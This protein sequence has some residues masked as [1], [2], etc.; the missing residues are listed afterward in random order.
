MRQNRGLE[1]AAET[2]ADV[3]SVAPLHPTGLRSRCSLEFPGGCAGSDHE[4]PAQQAAGHKEL[5]GQVE[6][7]DREEGQEADMKPRDFPT[8]SAVHGGDEPVIIDMSLDGPRKREPTLGVR[9]QPQTTS[10]RRRPR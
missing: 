6:L 9:V 7:R 3:P 1:E 8:G 5:G 10:V 4:D 2:A